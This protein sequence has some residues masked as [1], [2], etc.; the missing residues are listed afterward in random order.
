MQC[1][2]EM[3]SWDQ[4]HSVRSRTSQKYDPADGTRAL[5]I[6]ASK[7]TPQCQTFQGGSGKATHG[8]Q[9]VVLRGSEVVGTSGVGLQEEDDT[10][11]RNEEEEATE[12]D[13]VAHFLLHRTQAIKDVCSTGD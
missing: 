5:P 7:A 6:G 9:D 3:Q 2:E 8:R 4:V 12:V 10:E 13:V 11:E 1:Y